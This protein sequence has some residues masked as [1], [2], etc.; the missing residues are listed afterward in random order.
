MDFLATALANPINRAILERLPRLGLGQPH[1][2]AGCIYQTSWNLASG[3]PPAENIKDYDV[4]YFDDR[5]LSYEA[6]DA[7][8]RAVANATADLGVTVDVKNQAR[9]HLW[10]RQRF[11]VERPP[12]RSCREAIAS[13]TAVAKCVGIAVSP[14]GALELVA[15]YGLDDT[16]AGVLR[17][18]PHCPDPESFRPKAESQQARWPWLRIVDPNGDA[19]QSASGS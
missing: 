8:V 14:D 10:Y 15:P 3:R 19:A 13:F 5:D 11:G 9:V 2:V 12:L 4:F 1:L 7:V 6:E 16:I 18:N 17:L